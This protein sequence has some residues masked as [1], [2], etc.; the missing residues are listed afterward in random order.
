MPMFAMVTGTITSCIG[1]GS[2][3]NLSFYAYLGTLGNVRTNRRKHFI[4][5]QVP[6]NNSSLLLKIDL[7]NTQTLQ[8]N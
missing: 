4:I 1:Y 2:E 3:L 7:Q 8:L 5:K 6:L